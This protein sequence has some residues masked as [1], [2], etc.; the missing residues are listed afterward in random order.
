MLHMEDGRGGEAGVEFGASC[1]RGDLRRR[2]PPALAERVVLRLE[3]LPEEERA[4]LRSVFVDNR[5]VKELAPLAGSSERV[6]RRKVK[7]ALS[8]VLGARFSFVLERRASWTVTRRR[9]ATL[10]YI[11]GMSVRETA[12]RTGLSLHAVRRHRDAIEAIF[13]AEHG[14]PAR[15]RRVR[16]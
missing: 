8:R 2:L 5:A 1:G 16:G 9:I 12:A 15:F 10:H 6:L 14:G 13:D 7:R 11:D 4:I 3:H